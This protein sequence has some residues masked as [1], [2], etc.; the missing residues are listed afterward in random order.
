MRDNWFDIIISALLL[1]IGVL[2]GTVELMTGHIAMGILLLGLS[3]VNIPL[4]A[5]NR[6][7]N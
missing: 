7:R 3:I 2:V 5:V 4:L 6:K 1:L